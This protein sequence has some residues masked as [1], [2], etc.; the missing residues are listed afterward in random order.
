MVLPTLTVGAATLASTVTVTVTP[1]DDA[2]TISQIV[3]GPV[4][5]NES[6]RQEY[7]E[8]LFNEFI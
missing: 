7:L 5:T 3:A 1:V 8:G 2:P 6:G 4:T